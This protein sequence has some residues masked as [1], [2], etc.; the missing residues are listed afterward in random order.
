MR[1]APKLGSTRPG[2]DA[3]SAPPADDAREVSL[4]L[5]GRE[6]AWGGRGACLQSVKGE[7]RTF[8]LKAAGSSLNSFAASR[9]AGESAFGV[10]SIEMTESSIDCTV[11]IGSHRS[12]ACSYPYWSSPGAWRMEMHTLPSV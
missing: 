11:W 8:F 10:E 2:S 9:L 12:D 6:E 7:G 4:K 1:P 5:S 3:R